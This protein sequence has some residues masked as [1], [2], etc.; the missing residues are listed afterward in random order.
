MFEL[1]QKIICLGEHLS[2]SDL[3][4]TSA[5]SVSEQKG[6]GDEKQNHCKNLEKMTSEC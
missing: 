3:S 6:L 5:A 4:I 1:V 2:D